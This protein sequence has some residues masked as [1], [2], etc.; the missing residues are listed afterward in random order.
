MATMS[1]FRDTVSADRSDRVDVT[2]MQQGSSR[3]EEALSLL[4]GK[5]AF[6]PG[7]FDIAAQAL[8]IGLGYRW[9]GIAVLRPGNRVEVLAMC[10][11]DGPVESTDYA[12][13]GTPCRQIYAAAESGDVDTHLFLDARVGAR[14]ASPALSRPD[15]GAYRGEAFFDPEGEPAGHVFAMHDRAVEDDRDARAFFTLVTQ[16]VGAEHSRW[17]A[18]DAL[19]ASEQ[20]TRA[21]EQRLRDA[22][23]NISDGFALYDADDRLVLYNRKWMDIYGYRRSDLRPGIRYEDLVRMDVE[24]DAIAGDAEQYIERRLAYRRTFE[25]SFDLQLKDDRWI[26]IR[27]SPTTDGGIVGIQTDITSRM[28][29]IEAVMAEKEAAEHVSDRKSDFLTKVSHEIRTPLNAIIGFAEIIR[30]ARFGPVGNAKYQDYAADIASSGQHV[31]E[32]VNSLLDLSRAE[33]GVD[34]LEEEVVDI[35]ETVRAALVFVRDAA[36]EKEISTELY[37]PNDVPKLRADPRKLKQILVNLLA[38]AVKYTDPGGRVSVTVKTDPRVGAAFR[39][40]DTGI[41]IAAEE[42]PQVLKMFG[43][44]R[45]ASHR[46]RE[47]T[48]LGLPLAASLV[49]LHGGTLDIDSEPQVG[50][51]VSVTFPPERLVPDEIRKHVEQ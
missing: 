44:G 29:A 2:A 11:P 23:E 5:A 39:I 34:E 26:T 3:R 9:G 22:I 33:A 41:G 25:G 19:L 47:G 10:G 12:L 38:N 32:L 8:V 21:A 20:R 7:F 51:T 43:R 36:R 45:T 37:F 35:T 28:R 46:G 16:R 15:I 18:E 48:G 42:M 24:L 27:E 49:E 31:L 6:G 14:F 4:A 40:A 1:A 13:D 30:K 17:L 50:T